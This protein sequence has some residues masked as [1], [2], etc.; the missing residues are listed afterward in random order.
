MLH[1][2]LTHV[3][4]DHDVLSTGGDLEQIRQAIREPSRGGAMKHKQGNGSSSSVPVPGQ[5]VNI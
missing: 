2:T 3:D 5:L 4:E 1:G